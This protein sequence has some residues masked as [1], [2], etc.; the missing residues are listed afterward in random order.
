MQSKIPTWTGIA[1]RTVLLAT[2]AMAAAIAGGV[3]AQV[4]PDKPVRLVVTFAPGGPT[5]VAARIIAQ[6]MS[7][8]LGQPVVVENRPGAASMIAAAYVAQQSRD[9]YTL[10]VT[11][12]QV[13]SN[14]L[15]YKKISYKNSDFAPVGLM[16]TATNAMT[17]PTSL[18]VKNVREFVEYAKKLPGGVSYAI[19]G[20]G[21]TPHVNGKMLEKAAGLTMT[22]VN[23]NGS[24]PATND[25]MAGRVQMMFNSVA[26]SLPLHEAGKL[27][28][29]GIASDK[30]MDVAPDIPTLKEQGVPVSLL[31]WFGLAAPAGTAPERIDILNRAL[32]K[33]V[34]HPDY[35]ERMKKLATTP[36]SNTPAEFGEF[37]KADYERWAEILKPMN[38]QLD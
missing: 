21:G 10:L 11:S 38:L 30:R 12:N 29:L 3:Q 18:P 24:A 22:E 9:G 7:Q 15:M 26:A 17:V 6:H 31:T 4:F 36:V 28:I 16:F 20:M 1:R 35:Q 5:D 34:A 19:L 32:V 33:A 13:N 27:R 14:P 8:A 23:Y 25:L 2:G 37:M